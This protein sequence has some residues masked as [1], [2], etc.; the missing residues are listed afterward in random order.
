MS[1]ERASETVAPGIGP[2]VEGIDALRA[3]YRRRRDEYDYQ[4]IHPAD[5][6]KYQESGWILHKE[7]QSHVWVKKS[8][9]ADQILEDRLWC[10]FYRMG[11]PVL[12][13]PKFRINYKKLD[14]S[15]GTKQI[16]VFA[17]D[18]E[19]VVVLACRAREVRGRRGLQRDLT[20]TAGLQKNFGQSIRTYFG[21]QFNPRIIWIYATHNIIWSEADVERA[22]TANIRVVTEN[23][24]QYFEAFISHI[25]AA[26]RYQFLAEFLEGSKIPNLENIRVP[27]VKGR[28]GRHT[29]YSFVVSAR[30]LL[31]IAFVNHQSLNHPD[32]RPAYQRM[33]NKKRIND[34]GMFIQH[35]GFFPT[36]ILVNFVDQCR[37][38]L[39]PNKDNTD[40]D[41]KFGWLYLPSKYKSAW[42]IDGQHR[43]YGF[44]NVPDNFLDTNLFVLAFE[45]MDTKTEADL[46]ITINHEQRSVSKSLLV[47]LQADLKVGSSDPKEAISAIASALVRSINN[48]NTSPF[49]RRFEIPGIPPADSQ[50]LTIAEAVKGL[51]RSTL[52]GRVL[53]K[54]SRISGFFS[55]ETDEDTI[56]RARRLLN[57]YFRSLMDANPER[58]EKGRAA[59]ICVNPGIRAHFQL[60]QEILAHLAST[61]AMD[62]M[63]EPPDKTVAALVDFIE[64]IREFI[65]GASDKQVEGKFSRKFGEGGVAEYFYNLC[66]IMQKKHKDFGSQEFK[67]Y[68]ERQADARVHQADEDINDLQHAISEVVIETLKKIHGTH[69]LQSGEKAYWDLGIDNLEIKQAAY[70]KQLM[71]PADKRS[72]KEAYLDLVDFEKIV[73][74]PNNWARFESIFNIPIA[75]EK[76]KK[77]YLLWLEKLNEIRRISAHKSPYRSYSEDDLEFVTWIK[78]ALFDNFAKAGFAFD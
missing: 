52:L 56:N 58:W 31:K 55:G 22:E 2:L 13:G 24:I 65:S 66:E 70:K 62:G 4:K 51:V 77:Y 10:L 71:V 76:G 45:K 9:S 28:F 11:Y 64:P 23:E 21:R 60:I 72:P 12:S 18:D 59:Y 63:V 14:G 1:N 5:Q 53:P 42:V 75:G 61:R 73:K 47:T 41:I 33:I 6:P 37:F 68:K 34:I 20:E 57:G 29:Y 25:G 78:G 8:K 67:K 50:N 26:G 27:A 69:E 19:T 44:S 74:Q 36:N 39:L 40:R 35:G 30:H 17:K 7:L 43:L 15:S 48:D 46:F 38:D 16:D 32:G 54:K 49:F 3:A